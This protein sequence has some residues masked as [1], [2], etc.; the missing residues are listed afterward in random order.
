MAPPMKGLVQFVA[1]LR[2]AR[3]R[4]AEAKRVNTE[5]ANIRQKFQDSSLNGYNKKKYVCKLI[6]MYT[7]GYEI[8]I[9]HAESVSLL[10][11]EKYSEKQIGYLA[12]SLMLN[13]HDDLLD[14]T[15]N[16]IRKDLA[17]M[18]DIN[19]CLALNCIATVGGKLLGIELSDEIFKL[20]ISPTSPNAVRK[21]AA[22]T[23]LRLYR[24][25]PNIVRPT[26]PDRVVAL[27]DDSDLGVTLAV[28]SLIIA[29]VQ[30]DPERYKLCHGKVVRRLQ[31]LVLQENYSQDY[32]YYNV[33]CP[34][35]LIKLFRILQYYPPST[36]ETVQT[37]MRKVIFKVVDQHSFTPNEGKD[38]E[39]SEEKSGGVNEHNAKNAVLFEVIS[40][41]IHLEVD[42]K[43]LHRIVEALGGYLVAPE[44]NVRY[45]SLT[46]FASLAARYDEVPVQ[47]YTNRVIRLLR[48]RDIS[49]RRK[50][51]DL[52]YCMCDSSNVRMIVAEL[53][54]YLQTA[55]YAMREEMVL[56][57]AIL[58]EKFATEYEWYVDTSLQLIS[59]AGNFVSDE[60]WQRVLQIVVNNESLQ[61]YAARA[62]F[63]HLKKSSASCPETMVKVGGYILG[64]Y[65]HLIADEPGISPIEQFLA[66]HD[67]FPTVSLY[68]R[69]LL[70]TTYIKFVN[71]F[72][73]IKSQLIQV[74]EF[75]STSMDSEIQQRACEYLRMAT[76]ADKTL[77]ATVWDEMP[78][79]PE[80]A[81]ALLSRLH[82][83]HAISEDKRVWNLG[84]KEAQQ[85]G[86]VF[87]HDQ[88]GSSHNLANGPPPPP[89]SR[90]VSSASGKGNMSS[91]EELQ[92]HD[93]LTSNWE[94]AFR[95]LLIHPEGMF[96][97][98]SL[99]QIGCKQE[100]RKHLGCV[101]L[102][103]KNVSGAKLQS[104]SVDLM[105]PCA[106]SVLHVSTKNFPESTLAPGATT[107]QVILIECKQPFA[108]SPTIKITY[109][110]GTLKVLHLKL[111][112][113]LDKFM[114]PASLSHEDY[115]NRWSQ[116]GTGSRE[117]QK[118]F[119]NISATSPIKL[120]LEDSQ[121]VKGLNWSIISGIDKNPDNLAGAG[122]IHTSVGGNFG[123][124]YRLEPN[125]TK[126]M[127]RITVRATDE[128]VPLILGKTLITVYTL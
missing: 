58:V 33:A 62:V 3:A 24:R 94:S 4:E 107:R 90:T 61:V 2:N 37:V 124:L 11:S 9:G 17:S 1:D 20:L 14:M 48:D 12:C 83:K 16:S 15:V 54:S 117:S 64:E 66:L 63:N 91:S 93:P 101:I 56:R 127:Y 110:A 86:N 70:L 92:K 51:I 120:N 106:E 112:V 78:P 80:K 105:N 111:P 36:D 69:G 52:L 108:Q 75:H 97:N 41:A 46:A 21:K 35:L 65:G 79:F 103:F 85:E 28:A 71:L 10:S 53:L 125:A 102:Y 95:H 22:L 73:E 39:S 31:S 25:S 126:T 57:L 26:W 119:K 6:Y 29:L 82:S 74:F 44:T 81:S 115:F 121:V 55:D 23:I 50:A 96:Y 43:L 89:V 5:L 45:L 30:D 116:I 113:T 77:L 34:W 8:D 100:Y 67:K 59:V 99:V 87:K 72:E 18:N 118:V 104:L 122:V 114:E 38:K 109:M 27:V 123:C 128:R 42:P 49:V 60:V 68:T 98:D 13:E 84:N 19:T 32:V 76:E 88:N 40:L 7:L 47:K